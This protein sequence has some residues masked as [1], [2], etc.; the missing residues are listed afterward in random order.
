MKI[1]DS[2]VGSTNSSDGVFGL[3]LPLVMV[4][5]GLFFV[6]FHFSKCTP[7]LSIHYSLEMNLTVNF[8]ADSR[9]PRI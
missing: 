7:I 2:H 3:G 6:C 1:Q 5:P 8:S 4:K 9:V